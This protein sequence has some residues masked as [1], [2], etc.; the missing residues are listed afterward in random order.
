MTDSTAEFFQD[1]DRRG[2]EPLLEKASGTVR[3]DL[4]VGSGTEHW[5]LAFD[6]GDVSVSREH[7]A[8]DCVVRTDKKV[9]D[10]LATGKL[11]GLTAYLRGEIGLEGN[12]E[13]LVLVQRVFP[14]P[15]TASGR[16]RP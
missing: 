7:R 10:G 15:A 6:D 14:A 13:L 3:F 1:L 9:F 12:P 4:S 2:H 16:D 8:A 11:N 5:L